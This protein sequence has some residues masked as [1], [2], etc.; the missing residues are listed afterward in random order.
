MF[1]SPLFGRRIHIA[2]SIDKDAAVATAAA[3]DHAR[4]LLQALVPALVAKGATF[5]IPVDADPKRD[6]DGKSICFDWLVWQAIRANIHRRPAGAH[7]PLVMAV[8][9]HKTDNQIPTEFQQLWDELRVTD[10]VNIENAAEWNMG[11]KRLEAAAHRGDILVTVGGTDGVLFLADL[12]HRAGKPVLPL[13]DPVAAASLGSR[14]LFNFGVQSAAGTRLF[15]T[16]SNTSQSWLNR[17]GS[18]RASPQERA[19]L[20][21]DLLEAL[22]PPTAFAVRLLD[23][24]HADY[25][26]VQQFFDGV[27]QPIV[28]GDL[29]YKLKVVDGRQKYDYPRIDQEIFASLQRSRLVIADLTGERPNCFLEAGFAIGRE[30]PT[31]VTC[32]KG[33]KLHFDLSTVA[34]HFWDSAQPLADGKAAFKEHVEAVRDR[35]P[36]APAQHLVF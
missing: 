3:V 31:I 26:A 33:G 18:L 4:E 15:R 35:P 1:R 2:G 10:A 36:L 11:A 27:V 8:L 14:K 6:V 9:H 21:V 25:P 30:I 24:S 20:A 5:V 28:E 22:E 23:S 16:V 13:P 12:Y 17:L 32:K 29:G 19:M 34:T 7:N